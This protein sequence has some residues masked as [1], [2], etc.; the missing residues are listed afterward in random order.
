MSHHP[1][2][3]AGVWLPIVTPFVDGEVDL[4]GYRRLLKSY[5]GRQISG[6]IPLGTTGE[7]PSLDDDEM[8]AIVEATME[9]VDERIPVYVGV[10]GNS[11]KKV[12]RTLRQLERYPFAG[13]LSICPYYNRPTEEGICEHFRQ[14]A[15]ATD[16]NVLI[17]NIPYRTAVNLSNDAVLSLSETPNIV[18]IKDSC[19]NL[20]QSIDLLRRRPPGFSVMTGDDALFYTMLALGG[21]GGILAAAHCRPEVFA[22]VYQ[23]MMANDHQGAHRAWSTIEPHVRVLSKEPNPLPLKHWLWREG[24]IAAPECRLP[25]TRISSVLAAEIESLGPG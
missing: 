13:I 6:V 1:P 12:V 7:S 3:V 9:V 20:A 25:M 11:T 4:D 15:A 22:A 10:G 16:R 19:A 5:I 21:D 23:R 24:A 14:I 8:L 18:G 17:Y 2:A